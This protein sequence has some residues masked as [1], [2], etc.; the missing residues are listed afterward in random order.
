MKWEFEC[1]A[2][3]DKLYRTLDPNVDHCLVCKKDVHLVHNMD[4]LKEKVY[5]KIIKKKGKQRKLHGI[6]MRLWATL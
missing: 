5:R 4:Q 1:P 2:T 6:G 3:L